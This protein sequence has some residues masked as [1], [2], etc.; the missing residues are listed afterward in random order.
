MATQTKKWY[1]EQ[2]KLIDK[3]LPKLKKLLN[4]ENIILNPVTIIINKRKHMRSLCGRWDGEKI[5]LY[6]YHYSG[7][8]KE[9][10]LHE[11]LHCFISQNKLWKYD[12]KSKL[13]NKLVLNLNTK[14]LRIGSCHGAYLWKYKC[15][16]GA[17]L[18]TNDKR[19]NGWR[20]SQCGEHIK[21]PIINMT[22]KIDFLINL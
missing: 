14:K 12:K 8:T 19:I 2:L 18:K 10:L 1:K 15:N 17:W 21:K 9:T 3:Y 5:I 4:T 20:C 11:L 13:F 6:K 22:K 16:C 7:L